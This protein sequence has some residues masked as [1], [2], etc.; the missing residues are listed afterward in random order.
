MRLRRSTSAATIA[1]AASV[2]IATF[3]V[4][5]AKGTDNA[6]L[7]EGGLVEEDA[8]R[9]VNVLP[10]QTDSSTANPDGSVL[11]PGD[12]STGGC[13]M[14]VVINELVSNGAG[15]A[16]DEMIELYNPSSCAVDLG[17]WE[18]KYESSG[19][20]VGAA[21][22]KF[23]VGDSI[24]SLGYLTLTPGG[25]TPWT[26]GMAAASGQVGLLDDKAKVIDAVAYGSV[27]MGD[28]RE[29]TSAAAPASG[30]SIGR[31]PN[32]SDTGNNK[33]DFKTYPAPSPGAPNP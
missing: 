30:G 23:L 8:G 21:G 32:G 9:D 18:L 27:T 2:A 1:F 29:G 10:V 24:P 11:P 19:G 5:C 22:H 25:S 6:T 31:S 20:G 26:P 17:S 14:K 3:L 12:S 28:Y 4:A 33:T 16:N 13:T 7:D 15:G